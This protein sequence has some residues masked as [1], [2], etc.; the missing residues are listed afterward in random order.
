MGLTNAFLRLS[1]LVFAATLFVPLV[2]AF[3]SRLNDPSPWTTAT[4]LG[5]PLVAAALAVVAFLVFR[6]LRSS[7]LRLDDLFVSQTRF[8]D[9]LPMRWVDVAIFGSAALSLFLE[10]AVI[11]WQGTVF[12]FFAFYKNFTLLSCFAGLGLGYSLASR[13]RTPLVA[14]IPLLVW[15]FLFLI[16]FRFGMPEWSLASVRNLPFQ[17]QL[18]MGVNVL[19]TFAEGVATYLLSLGHVRH[20]GARVPPRR[21]DCAAA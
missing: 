13:D 18:N 5:Y 16:G 15:Q 8:F 12:E 10:L 3:C 4:Y 20:D 9:E 14:V 21:A 1:A 7:E 11:R 17:E 2:T 6:V 19:T